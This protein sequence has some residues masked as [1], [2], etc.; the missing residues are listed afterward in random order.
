MHGKVNGLMFQNGKLIIVSCVINESKSYVPPR[1]L[2]AKDT[3]FGASAIIVVT[4][5][6][7]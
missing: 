7:V 4:Y 2:L 1:V 3:Q 5:V 6:V